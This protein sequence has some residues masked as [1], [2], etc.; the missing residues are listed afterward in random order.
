MADGTGHS[1]TRTVASRPRSVP[2]A[3]LDPVADLDGPGRAG[4]E[5]SHAVG[6][7]RDDTPLRDDLV[8]VVFG[9]PRRRLRRADRGRARADL[10]QPAL[11]LVA[12]ADDVEAI[13]HLHAVLR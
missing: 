5:K 4:D 10:A 7:H 3:H 13:A 2:V 11:P 8:G 1:V 9:L 6:T 12:L